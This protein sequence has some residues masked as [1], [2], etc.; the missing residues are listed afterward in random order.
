MGHQWMGLVQIKCE[1]DLGHL[2]EAGAAS[3]D[4]RQRLKATDATVRITVLCCWPHEADS[5][6][7][8]CAYSWAGSLPKPQDMGVH[9]V[10]A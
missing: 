5:I 4:P 10:G 7:A 3:D 8:V 9:W 2:A 1:K 6:V